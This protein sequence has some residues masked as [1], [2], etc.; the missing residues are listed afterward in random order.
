MNRLPP[1]HVARAIALAQG[2]AVAPLAAVKNPRAAARVGVDGLNGTER[3]FAE[4]LELRRR[5]GR[6]LFWTPHPF[7]LRLAASTHYRP[8]F[9]VVLADGSTDVVEIKGHWEDD[10]RAKIKV[11]ARLFPVWRFLAVRWD[12]Q[13]KNWATEEIPSA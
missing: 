2:R 1:P 11:A 3:R 10:A 5:A 7:S 12:R 8:D 9:L 6:V 4:D 13:A